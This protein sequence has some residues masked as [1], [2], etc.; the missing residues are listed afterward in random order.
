MSVTTHFAGF[1][2]RHVLGPSLI[3]RNPFL[4]GR[5]RATVDQSEHMDFAQRRAWADQHLHRT[6][7][8]ASRTRYG[9]S[10]GGGSELA[11]W[12]ML[13]KERLRGNLESFTTGNT[14]FSAPAVTGGTTGN[15]LRLVRSMRGV[16][17]E[18]ACLDWLIKR[19]GA[20]PVKDRVAL[21]RGDNIKDPTDLKPPHWVTNNGGRSMVFSSNMLGRETIVDYVRALQDFSPT[22]LCAY[23]TSLECL[24]RLIREHNLKLHIPCVL[25]SS[26]VLK[27]EAWSLA[28]ETLGC[29]LIDYY[30]QAERVAFA[31]ANAPREYHFMPTYSYVEFIP[32]KVDAIGEAAHV[33]VYEIVGTT[34]W[35]DLMPLVRYRTGDLVRLPEHW[36]ARE[37]EEVALGL[38]PFNGVLGREQEILVCPKGVRLTGIDHIPRHV[39]NILRIQVIQ[40]SLHE[41]CILVL[42]AP[43]FGERDAAQLLQNAREKVPDSIRL[44]VETAQWLERTPRGKT[45]LVIHRK[46]VQ[47]L[48][49]L[50]GVEPA[51]TR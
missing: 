4:Y 34:Y 45:P 16:V 11:S 21:L 19:L 36:G 7:E 29:E 48:L 23:P 12:P 43:G 18:Q 32:Y 13:D 5:T 3:R 25:T 8:L 14:L 33:G 15:P 42:P 46:P 49:R 28:R 27:S 17:F 40:E 2:K 10:V 51:L 35:N 38:R 47:E 20:D 30:G 31:Y 37:L 39:E 24:C 22:M 50:Q 26:E 6:L 41:V 1:M 9:R 44:R